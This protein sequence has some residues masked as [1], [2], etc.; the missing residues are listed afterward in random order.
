[1]ITIQDFQE[2]SI[3]WVEPMGE[4]QEAI[5]LIIKNFTQIHAKRIH[6]GKICLAVQFALNPWN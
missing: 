6:V 1:M 5:K 2:G 3:R 4:W